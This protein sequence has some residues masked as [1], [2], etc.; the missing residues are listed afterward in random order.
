MHRFECPH[1]A[2]L[3]DLT[4]KMKAWQDGGDHLIILTDFNNDITDPTVHNWVA[5]LGLVEAITYLHPERAPPTYQRGSRPID[6]IFTEPQLLAFA[7]QRI[8]KFWRCDS[9]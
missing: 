5:N 8:S 6:G 4:I 9:K 7:L 3:K 1:K 2:I